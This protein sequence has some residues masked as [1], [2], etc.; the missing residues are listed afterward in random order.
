M[1]RHHGHSA[2]VP[3]RMTV[4]GDSFVGTPRRLSSE[5]DF[6][7]PEV[8]F[9]FA[10]AVEEARS[11]LCQLLA[12]MAEGGISREGARAGLPLAAGTYNSLSKMGAV[13]PRGHD[14]GFL[15]PG[16]GARW[17]EA[18]C[19]GLAEGARGDSARAGGGEERP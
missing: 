1:Y 11:A 5:E 13:V 16:I 3:A 2:R 12:Q 6:A 10:R 9:L 17:L 4:T 14:G 7:T 15:T 8:V 19:S 18:V